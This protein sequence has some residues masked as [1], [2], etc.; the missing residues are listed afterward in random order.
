M[1]KLVSV[2]RTVLL[3]VLS[4]VAIAQEV[5]ID[6]ASDTGEPRTLRAEFFGQSDPA[7]SWAV[8]AA[9]YRHLQYQASQSAGLPISVLKSRVGIGEDLADHV[10]Y[11]G[12]DYL[13]S[14]QRLQEESRRNSGLATV[15]VPPGGGALQLTPPVERRAPNESDLALL[16]RARPLELPRRG[17][18][19][20]TPEVSLMREDPLVA[21]EGEARAAVETH[22]LELLRVIGA[23]NYSALDRWV[24]LEFGEQVRVPRQASRAPSLGVDR[25]D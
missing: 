4:G 7:P 5:V 1:E 8:W 23:R 20:T 6:V 17:E 18:D 24:T 12:R 9:F 25:K 21:F 13:Q 2:A 22:K 10:M 19:G 11:L 16:A 15:V 3:G 14:L